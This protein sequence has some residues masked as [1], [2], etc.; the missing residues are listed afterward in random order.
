RAGRPD[1]VPRGRET[2]R[3]GARARSLPVARDGRSVRTRCLSAATGYVANVPRECQ[4]PVTLSFVWVAGAPPPA[5]PTWP[6][7][8][9]AVGADGRS[10][11][12]FHARRLTLCPP[13]FRS[14][15]RF[16][17]PAA[18]RRF[19]VARKKCPCPSGTT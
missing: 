4:D 6:N 12:A 2:E 15:R 11:L 18:T 1:V 7:R 16:V 3:L 19:P 13:C 9:T 17:C 10:F 5:P 14:R 8:K